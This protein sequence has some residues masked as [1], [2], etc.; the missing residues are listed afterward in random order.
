MNAEL[1]DLLQN[2]DDLINTNELLEMFDIKR[3]T[4]ER[5]RREGLPFTKINNK[6]FFKKSLVMEWIKEN[7]S[8]QLVIY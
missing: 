4:I 7:K 3:I 5:W 6:I 2:K 1:K 8:D